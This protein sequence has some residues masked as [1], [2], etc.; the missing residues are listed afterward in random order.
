MEERQ[1]LV[2]HVE[3]RHG[4][5]VYRADYFVED[6]VIHAWIGERALLTPVNNCPACDTVKVLLA[7]HLM[8]QDRKIGQANRWQN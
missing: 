5:E 2:Q 4:G 3:V 8:Q 7:G 6:N 1:G